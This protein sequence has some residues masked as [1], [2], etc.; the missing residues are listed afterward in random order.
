MRVSRAGLLELWNRVI[1]VDVKENVYLNGENNLYPN[2]IERVVL[3]SPTARRASNML[4]KFI[5]GSGITLRDGSTDMLVNRRK[6]LYLTDIIKRS[7]EDIAVQD[8]AF[9]RVGYVFNDQ[10]NELEP[11][12]IEVLNYTRCRISKEDDDDNP[13]KIIYKDFEEKKSMFR[14]GAKQKWFYPF[15]PDQNVVLAQMQNDTPDKP[16]DEQIKNYRGQVMYL[17]LTPKFTYASS[18]FESVYND[19]DT[20]Y[21]MSLYSNAITREGFLGKVAVLTQGLDDEQ[22]KQVDEDLQMWLGAEN[23]SHLFRL[24]LENADD[25]DKVLKIITVESQYDDDQFVNLDKRIRRNILGAANN[26]PE[27]MVNSTEGAMFG[28]SGDAYRELKE[29]YSE[30]TEGERRALER[31]FRQMGIYVEIHELGKEVV[32]V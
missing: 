7:A 26:I 1:K 14:K 19:C 10:T 29:F 4:A 27:Q 21:R 20:E 13:G 11:R 8:G 12:P 32:P 31:A 28:S 15:N 17:N 24:D 25:L 2:E 23:A 5:A 6:G 30:Q 22:A 18:K 9:I 3:N 16:I